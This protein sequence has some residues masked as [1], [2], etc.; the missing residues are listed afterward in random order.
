MERYNQPIIILEGLYF[1]QK[2]QLKVSEFYSN[3]KYLQGDTDEM[4]RVKP[5]YN[6]VNFRVTLAKVA[7]DLD[8][9]D[10]QL[11]SD[12]PTQ[13]VQAMLLNRE[14]F[15]WMKESNFS[16]FLNEFTL[17][18]AKYGGVLIKKTMEKGELKISV[19]DWRNVYTDQMDIINNPITEVHYMTPLELQKKKGK[20]NGIDKLMKEIELYNS[21]CKRK[22]QLIHRLEV[23]ETRGEFTKA[24]LKES[25]K[26]EVADSDLWNYSE[27][28][29]FTT[30]VG[31]KD[32]VLF[33]EETK[34]KV[35]KY[36][37]WE[38]MP[39]R[40][41]GRGVIEDSE[42][43][44][45][46]MNHAVINENNAMDLAGKVA[47]KTNSTEIGDNILE[48]DNGKIFKL[49]ANED[50]N[51][52]QLVPS[53][54][55]QFQAQINRWRDQVD[56]ATNAYDANTGEQPPSGTPYSQTVFLSQVAS[57]PYD[58]R[59]EQAGIFFQE[60]FKDWI[61][62]YL[63]RKLYKEHILVTD[64]TEEELKVIDKAFI[65]FANKSFIDKML[66][67]PMGAEAPTQENYNE[68]LKEIMSDVKGKG[69]KRYI[70]I[71]EGFF[72][73]AEVKST[74]TISNE[75]KNK[76]IILQSL[77]SILQTVIA[78]YDPNTKK[79]AVLEDPKLSK[80]FGS[81][82]EMSGV[83]GLSPASLGI[84]EF[85]NTGEAPAPALAPQPELIV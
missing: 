10:F 25:L 66:E 61:F 64:F 22:N 16:K 50:I 12:N 37:S 62:P 27:Q 14:N 9:K 63:K 33:A 80:I 59:I 46:W 23:F 73:D 51:T 18:R 40:A 34:E 4:G 84:G 48:V 19:V 55:G 5:F 39:G 83:P 30:S 72:D 53:A 69:A 38:E 6:I 45:I 36:L 81:I 82:L 85:G 74:L 21:K 2:D 13:Q 57:R 41:L 52:L 20:W 75:T 67:Q 68:F 58:F 42:Q 56:N 44:Q 78:S 65:K 1:S 31:D 15:E 71:P 77:S 54:L 60:V 49:G 26:Q 70:K 24:E 43:A 11:T 28:V 76:A 8:I 3:S 79:F 32:L 7:T 35:Y 17:N 29:Y 47:M